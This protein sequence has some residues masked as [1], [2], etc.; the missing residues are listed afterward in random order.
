MN[1]SSERST[2]LWME[3]NAAEGPPPL[4]GED[5]A[6]VAV[7]G[8]GIAGLSTAYELA[9][10]GRS[11]IVLDRGPLTGGMTSRTTAHLASACDDF[12]H[13]LIGMRG[14]EDARAFHQSQVAAI[15]RV[16]AIVEAEQIDCDF[17]RVDGHLFAA[18][19]EDRDLL[20]RELAACREVGAEEAGLLPSAPLPGADGRACIRF[21]G[22]ARFHP[23]KY[24]NGLIAALRRAGARLYANPA[25]ESV[26]EAEGGVTVRCVGGATVHA[27]AAVI[28][29]NSPVNDWLAIHSKQAP[30]RTYVVAGPVPRGS[31]PDALFWDTADPYHYVRLQPRDDAHDVLIV[32]GEDHKTGHAGAD[33][34]QDRLERLEAWAR[35]F[36]PSLG[37][38]ERRWS[39]QV[40]EPFDGL[41]FIGRN[42]GNAE[43]YVATGDSG[44]GI[45]NGVAAGILLRELILGREHPWAAAFDPRRKATSTGAAREFLKENID[46]AAHVAAHLTPGEVGSIDDLQPGRGAII[47]QGMT[48]I[49]AY[50]AESGRLYMHSATCTH[51]GCVLE[52]NPFEVCWDCPCHGSQFA[53]EGGVLNGPAIHPLRTLD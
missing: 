48:K 45:T 17:Q 53:P 16:E 7:V 51:T 23:R 39:G 12:Y 18:S 26:D 13:E 41:P 21:R 10:A 29:T 49:A 19:A 11:V 25:V 37:A 50:K 52:W 2:S 3:T 36:F 28:A 42:H 44:Q 8:S 31:V 9:Q 22:Q 5:R 40:M 38:V 4:G 46:A 27:K 32:G 6:D 24:L 43:V 34:I 14:L 20:D 1:S 15:A 30:Y 33:E 35:G 47:R